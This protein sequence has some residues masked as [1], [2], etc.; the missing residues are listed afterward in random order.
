MQQAEAVQEQ[1]ETWPYPRVPLLQGV[2]REDLWQLNWSWMQ[3]QAQ[4]SI[5]TVRPRIWITGCGTLQPYLIGL[6]NP[7]AEILA[8]DVSN[9]SLKMAERRCRLHGVGNV[10]FAQVDLTQKQSLPE[11]PFDW[12][13]SFGVLMCLPDPQA[14]LGELQQRLAPSGLLRTMV[15]PHFGRRRVFQIQRLAKLLGLRLQNPAHP[16]ILQ[17]MLQS[18]PR[19]HPL[20][21]AFDTYFDAQNPEGIV[22]A[23]LH[24]ADRGFTG[25]EWAALTSRAGL[26]PAFFMH[27]PWGQPQ[28]VLP[29]LGY[30]EVPLDLALHYL[31]VW[32][33]LRSNFITVFK[34]QGA[35]AVAPSAHWQHPLFDWRRLRAMPFYRLRL[36]K[37]ALMGTKLTSRTHEEN[38]QLS[39]GD[40]RNV[41]GWSPNRHSPTTLASRALSLPQKTLWG[42]DAYAHEERFHRP[43]KGKGVPNPFYGQLFDA[44]FF[45]LGLK[46]P[47]AWPSLHEEDRRWAALGSPLEN[48]DIPWGLTPH[49]TFQCHREAI[50]A[51][52]ANNPDASPAKDWKEVRLQDDDAKIEQVK[53][54]SAQW[55]GLEVL[56]A[57][58]VW[59]ELWVLLFSYEHLF[60]DINEL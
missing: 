30:S 60:L 19:R 12:I 28:Q 8:T 37:H 56:D 32:Q 3:R 36:L 57:S 16:Q 27:R 20:R 9:R 50:T 24:A 14:T 29:Q 59:R 54:W 47:K 18:L 38:I 49:H 43:R 45:H 51:W 42:D 23:F 15:Y 10:S 25:L 53:S 5:D 55:P 6:A 52:L 44:W 4:N 21:Y 40:F 31:D 33:E 34:R 58:H 13:E 35:P 48:E 2:R 26:V 41:L 11:G 22:D 17:N 39:A 7:E 1:Y 46:G